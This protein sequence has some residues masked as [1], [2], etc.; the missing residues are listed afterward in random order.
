MDAW[1]SGID[2]LLSLSRLCGHLEQ[3]FH[4]ALNSFWVSAFFVFFLFFY[5]FE[6]ASIE[7][8]NANSIAEA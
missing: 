6:C 3:V 2:S 8:L 1:H 4:E 7:L 5:F